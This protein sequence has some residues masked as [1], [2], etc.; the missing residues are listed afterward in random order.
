MIVFGLMLA[1]SISCN[2]QIQSGAP[3]PPLTRDE[4]VDLCK[5]PIFRDHPDKVL[6][7]FIRKYKIAFLPTKRDI[8]YLNENG[9]SKSITDQLK[10]NFASRIMYR[11]CQFTASSPQDSSFTEV[12]NTR[13]EATRFK[14]KTPGSLLY[15][16][17][18]DP[19]P[20]PTGGLSVADL[21]QYPHVGYVLIMG[22]VDADE[23][24]PV[25]RNITARLVFVSR[26]QQAMSI[27][28]PL[29]VEA[30][31]SADFDKVAKQI[32]EWSIREVEN[33]VR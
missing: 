31:G 14:I 12:L 8:A 7:D 1:C 25:K 26:E 10:Y 13:L 27:V 18:F 6:E 11:V 15:D 2:G 3:S 28:P 17:T 23:Q 4:L 19:V 5:R 21:N 32:A 9:V 20:C 22:A 16:K 30:N 29:T 33:Q 24:N